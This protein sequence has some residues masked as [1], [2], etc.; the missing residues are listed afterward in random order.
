MAS[1]E[2][3][4]PGWIAFLDRHIRVTEAHD[5]RL[6]AGLHIDSRLLRAARCAERTVKGDFSAFV[7]CHNGLGV[8]KKMMDAMSLAS[9]SSHS[10]S[11]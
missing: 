3:L 1:V 11:S 2:R 7:V 8:L 6:V 10:S 9:G 4:P 5:L